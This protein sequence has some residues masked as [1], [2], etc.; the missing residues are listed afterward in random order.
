MNVIGTVVEIKKNATIK[1]KTGNYT[2]YKLTYRD[3]EDSLKEQAFHEKALQYNAALKNGL[4]QL[5]PDDEFT[6][7][8]EKEGEYWNVK[9]IFKGSQAETKPAAKAASAAPSNGGSTYATKEERAQT[10]VYIVRQ[11]SITAALKL[12]EVNG[13]KKATVSDVLKD[14]TQF[15]QWVMFGKVLDSQTDFEDDDF[16]S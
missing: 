10:Q 5:E 2:G 8:K 6:M 16:P 12:A 9:N 4:D 7:V 13:N 11:S 14:A 15:E 3:K 1:G